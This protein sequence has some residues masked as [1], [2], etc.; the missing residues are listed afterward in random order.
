MKEEQSYEE[1]RF[2]KPIDLSV[3]EGLLKFNLG[4]VKVEGEK[5]LIDNFGNEEDY[6]I[7]L[8]PYTVE[9]KKKI[10]ALTI[11]FDKDSDEREIKVFSIKKLENDEYILVGD[12]NSLGENLDIEIVNKYFG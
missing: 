5:T 10:F 3:F 7:Y 6:T 8:V 9:E 4:L 1:L 2:K 11:K 12:V